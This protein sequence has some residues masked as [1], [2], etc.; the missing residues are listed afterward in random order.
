MYLNLFHTR[1]LKQRL[2]LLGKKVE[3]IPKSA[4]TEKDQIDNFLKERRLMRSLEMFVGGRL[5]E[6]DLRLR[7]KNHMIL[8]YDVLIIQK[9]SILTARKP[10]QEDSNLSIAQVD[11]HNSEG[12]LNMEEYHLELDEQAFMECMEEQAI[13]QAKIDAEQER[14]DKERR[15]QQEWEEKHD[16][17]NPANWKKESIEKGPY[18]QQYHEIF[19]PSI[20]SQPTQQSGVWVVDTTVTTAYI[21][22]ALAVEISET[23]KV[24]EEA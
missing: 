16:Y 8:S 22:E 17:F 2:S 14:L 1:S 13:E 21:E 23:T 6:G 19:I 5:Y 4:W 20:H 10:G 18:N 15:E 3:A 9:D 24:G 11:P 7:Q 12:Y